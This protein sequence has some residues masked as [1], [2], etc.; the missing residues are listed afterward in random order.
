MKKLKKIGSLVALSTGLLV[1]GGVNAHAESPYD[2]LKSQA[3]KEKSSVVQKLSPSEFS[4][5]NPLVRNKKLD[6]TKRYDLTG[7]V[8]YESEPN[9]DITTANY[10]NRGDM[11]IGT[12]DYQDIDT[13]RIDV[14]Q[15]TPIVVAGL[16]DRT[17]LSD[18]GIVLTDSLDNPIYPVS[19]S[20]G[21]HQVGWVF[22]LPAGTY[23]VNTF[24][25]TDY[26]TSDPY[27]IA[28][29][30]ANN[31]TD[32]IPPEAPVV[33]KIYDNSS[34]FTGIAEPNSTVIAKVG[35][36]E[37]GSANAG[38]DGKYSLYIPS[39]KA[40]T[41]ISVYAMDSAGNV[42][43]PTTVTVQHY[44]LN[45]WVVQNGKSYFYKN[46]VK[47][48]GWLYQG[49]KWFYL[50]KSTGAKTTGWVLDGGKRY[51]LDNYG[52]M[53]TGW[54]KSGNDWYYLGSNGAMKTGWQKIN[55]KWYYFYSNG[56]MAHDTKIG[57]YRLGHNGAMI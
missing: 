6:S 5:I 11:V 24:N 39:Q 31:I 23:Y 16:M 22:D 52:V 1:L 57:K 21:D 8:F 35:D 38:T 20:T 7:N 15:N 2:S 9:N 46:G 41:V 29:D 32:T 18:I 33:N 26:T 34:Y 47:Q 49:G 56:K 4:K 45:G 50:N 10:L 43:T 55:G 25:M 48:T 19:G 51:Y 44:V 13:F 17:S 28:W 27:S 30:Y 40:E 14:T 3:L 37:I 53:K 12:F 42:S 54:L 36:N